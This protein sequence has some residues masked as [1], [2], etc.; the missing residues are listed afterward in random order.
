LGKGFDVNT[1]SEAQD[2]LREAQRGSEEAFARLMELCARPLHAFVLLRIR[3]REVSQE[4]VQETFV[5]ALLGLQRVD[6]AREFIPWLLGIAAHVISEWK[7]KEELHQRT[8][9]AVAELHRGEAPGQ[10]AARDPQAAGV[11][12]ERILQA[13]AECPESYHLPLTMRYL[14][15]MSYEEIAVQLQL[16]AGQTKGLLYRGKQMLREKLADLDVDRGAQGEDSLTPRTPPLGVSGI[17]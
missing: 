9:S 13:I 12:Y 11:I 5:R 15:E 7:R 2:C 10:V 6:A 16:S 17:H 3:N 4:L 1:E 8:L 14:N